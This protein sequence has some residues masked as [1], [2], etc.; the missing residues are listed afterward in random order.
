MYNIAVIITGGTIASS[1]KDNYISLND[2]KSKYKIIELFK[3]KNPD[4]ALGINFSVFNPFTILSENLSGRYINTLIKSVK[5]IL[6]NDVKYDGIIITHGTDTL[7][8]SA[9]ALAIALPDINLPV[10][11]VSSN[12]IL[13]DKR[14]NGLMNFTQAVEYITAYDM[15]G[16]YVSYDGSVLDGFCLLPHIPYSDK[17]Y[18]FG[19]ADD[20][21]KGSSAKKF[22]ISENISF[23]EISLK[24]TSPVLHL[25]SVPGQAYPKLADTDIKA[26]L[27]ETYHSGTLGTDSKEL[28]EFCEN[29]NR[30][31][32]PV[33]VVGLDNRTQ[34][35]STRLYNNL[36]LNILPKISPISAYMYLWFKYSA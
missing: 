27:L 18:A 26:V 33:Y 35:E 12:Y 22:L 34:Y 9:A 1:E 2:G 7:Q 32:I 36:Y 19:H 14:A 10:I 15:S 13:E 21:S 30:Q 29:A 24:D 8:Y 4:T 31:N 5:E 17:V 25:K 16:V 28:Q 20:L 6:N 11:F 23:D 3:E